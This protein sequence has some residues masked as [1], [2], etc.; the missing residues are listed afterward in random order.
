MFTIITPQSIFIRQIL[1]A[2]TCKICLAATVRAD[3][4]QIPRRERR[5]LEVRNRILEASVELVE[6]NGVEATRVVEIC[7]RAD[8]A[9]KTFFN[10]FASKQHL[11]SEIA[12]HALNELLADIEQARKQL[13]STRGRIQHFFE[14]LAHN[15]DEAGPMHRELINEIVR[16]IHEEGD[17]PDQAR[18]LH[19]AFE[20]IIREG[21]VS[22][23]L[24]DRHSFETLT[25]ML[26]G[27]FYVLMFNWANLNGYPMRERALA[28]ARFLA[29]SMTIPKEE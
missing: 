4:Q 1:L 20:S 23:D 8:V 12:R 2:L 29:D 22:G 27:A 28:T 13:T 6:A 15:V 16:I 3:P 5:K 18:K 11:L 17:E 26:M 7:E 21:A 14:N 25:E 24:T 19:D 10:H 9:H